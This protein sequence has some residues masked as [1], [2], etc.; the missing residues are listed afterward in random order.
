MTCENI[1]DLIEDNFN[2]YLKKEGKTKEGSDLYDLV[3]IYVEC[4]FKYA[5]DFSNTKCGKVVNRDH[6]T[7]CY[8]M[9][10]INERNEFHIQGFE[11]YYIFRAKVLEKVKQAVFD[12]EIKID[13]ERFY[14]VETALSKYKSLVEYYKKNYHQANNKHN[15]YKRINKIRFQDLQYKYDKLKKSYENLAGSIVI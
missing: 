11:P 3:L 10:K 2:L 4:C 12:F 15:K 14:D 6:S 9:T 7:I 5:I 8:A 13:K 1:R